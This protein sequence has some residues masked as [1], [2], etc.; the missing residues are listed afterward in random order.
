[1]LNLNIC[2]MVYWLRK[3]LRAKLYFSLVGF[4]WASEKRLHKPNEKVLVA[5]SSN[6]VHV[7]KSKNNQVLWVIWRIIQWWNWWNLTMKVTNFSKLVTD[8][9]RLLIIPKLWTLITLMFFWSTQ[10]FKST[11]KFNRNC[12]TFQTVSHQF[13]PC[14][15][16]HYVP[17]FSIYSPSHSFHHFNKVF[18]LQKSP[19]SPP[20]SPRPLKRNQ[21][22]PKCEKNNNE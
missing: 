16:F 19:P 21:N 15:I 17:L 4:C 2:F 18:P 20:H 7:K 11:M 6:N 5:S 13:F 10:S 3:L 12:S 1:M 14:F 22:R 8:K 9:V